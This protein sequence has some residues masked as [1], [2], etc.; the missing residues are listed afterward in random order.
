MKVK[1]LILSHPIGDI[2]NAFI[3]R[4]RIKTKHLEKALRR[5]MDFILTLCDIEP[6]ETGY[7]L[8]GIY[9]FDENGEFLNPCLYV[10]K[11][12]ISEFDSASEIAQLKDIAE[13]D[14][15]DVEVAERLAHIRFC[16]ENY[17]FEFAPWKEILGYEL[18]AHNVQEVGPAALC[19]EILYEMTFFGFDEDKVETE[20]QKLYETVRESEE[21]RK[22]PQE[23]QKKH[24]I[25][26]EK[27]FAEFGIP[28][29]TE[30]E[31]QSDPVSYTHLTLPTICSV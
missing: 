31:Q 5:M 30:E 16:P 11:D 24:F 7:L 1:D 18:D 26:A 15:L 2:A 19:A 28:E 9:H 10:K 21:F 22:L 17:G 14:A 20:R 6:C 13:I 3:D 4:L 8:L 29:R 23:E 25:P 12:L 27:L